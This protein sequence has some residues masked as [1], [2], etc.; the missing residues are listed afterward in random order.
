MILTLVHSHSRMSLVVRCVWWGF[1][2]ARGTGA[3][4]ASPWVNT[5]GMQ[6]HIDEIE[7]NVADGAHTVLIMDCA[8]WH[9]NSELVM[10]TNITPILLP[11]QALEFNPVEN[12]WQYMRA[13]WLS[14]RVF[15]NYDAITE[16][17][18]QAWNYLIE[19]PDTIT[20]IGKRELA[21]VGRS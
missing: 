3:A 6:A 4:I 10:P 15:E 12:I 19:V 13:N 17:I 9:A 7:R 14:N 2:P 18:C 21:H 20:S 8:G 5:E 11:P 16:A 1:C